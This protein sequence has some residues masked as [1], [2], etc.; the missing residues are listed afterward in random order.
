MLGK[1]VLDVARYSTAVFQ[2]D[3]SQPLPQES[4]SDRTRY[5]LRGEFTL[6]GVSRRAEG[7][8]VGLDAASELARGLQRRGRLACQFAQR[9]VEVLQARPRHGPLRAPGSDRG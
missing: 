7:L 5:I 6:H 1:D 4:Q 2:I 3:S 8:A 9:L